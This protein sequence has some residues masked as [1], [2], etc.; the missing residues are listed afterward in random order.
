MNAV[1]KGTHIWCST[2]NA[3]TQPTILHVTS[4]LLF[5]WRRQNKLHLPVHFLLVGSMVVSLLVSI[6]FLGAATL[7]YPGGEAMAH[8][9]QMA[10][11]HQLQSKLM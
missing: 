2:G 6:C 10:S 3:H 8:L 11:A 5:R 9:H 1:R 7:N 4:A